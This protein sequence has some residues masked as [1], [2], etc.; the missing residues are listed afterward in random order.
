MA[1][2]ENMLLD[3][4]C[5][6]LART[7]VRASSMTIQ[8]SSIDPFLKSSVQKQDS[9]QVLGMA[10]TFCNSTSA[11]QTASCLDYLLPVFWKG[12]MFAYPKKRHPLL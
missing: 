12:L 9:S 3:A 11:Q 10:E 2:L 1:V 6:N 4:T 5:G 7:W 8:K